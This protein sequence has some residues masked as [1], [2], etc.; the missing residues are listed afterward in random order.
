MI[1]FKLMTDIEDIIIS[2]IG[3]PLFSSLKDVV[4]NNAYHDHE[5]VYDHLLK[6]LDVA[7]KSIDGNFIKNEKAKKLFLNFLEEPVGNLKN[8]DVLLLLALLHDI[9]KILKYKEDGKEESIVLKKEDGTT[10][11]PG[12]EYWGS[13]LTSE[14]LKEVNLSQNVIDFIEKGIRLHAD[15]GKDYF[16]TK[17][18]WSLE[19]II[20]DIKG[21]AEGI[22][23]EIL[24][25]IYC[26]C[27]YAKPFQLTKATII[28]LFNEPSLYT[29]RE[30]YIP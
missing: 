13:A 1:K 5:K 9:G 27:F 19:K 6:T 20:E 11:C 2:I 22:Y 24:F 7:R 18:G 30:Y 28:N 8:K 26:D 15:L 17:I 10:L 29:E 16:E 3:S 25:N 4:E 21:R 23:K 12:H 14:V